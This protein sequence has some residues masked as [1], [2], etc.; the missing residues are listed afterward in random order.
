MPCVHLGRQSGVSVMG[1]P[2]KRWVL[3]E[4]KGGI[5][6]GPGPRDTYWTVHADA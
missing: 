4:K 2:D 3:W 6:D 1:S 5:K